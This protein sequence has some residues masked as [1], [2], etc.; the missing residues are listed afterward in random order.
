MEGFVSTSVSE[1]HLGEGGNVRRRAWQ[2]IFGV[3][4]LLLLLAYLS[5]ESHES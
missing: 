4:V 5:S 2:R 3:T 1:G